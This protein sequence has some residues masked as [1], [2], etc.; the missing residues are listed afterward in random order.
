MKVAFRDDCCEVFAKESLWTVIY[1]FYGNI[2]Y[3]GK[4]V[5]CPGSPQVQS[6]L[7]LYRE[8]QSRIT[9]SVSAATTPRCPVPHSDIRCWNA[10]TKHILSVSKVVFHGNGIWAKS[11]CVLSGAACCRRRRDHVR[12]ERSA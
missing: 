3:T 7:S 9:S 6:S 12:S 2:A 5:W 8:V 11:H 4:H 1:A 10:K